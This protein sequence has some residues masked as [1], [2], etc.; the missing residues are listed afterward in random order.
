MHKEW[1]KLGEFL[2]V[3]YND[4]V[5]KK[6]SGGQFERTEDGIGAAP[7]RPGYPEDY[8]RRVIQETGMRYKVPE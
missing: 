2:I 8:N 3:K 4:M 5:V 6:V 1:R 7:E